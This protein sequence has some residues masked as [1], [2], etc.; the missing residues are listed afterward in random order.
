MNNGHEK[1]DL[2]AVYSAV[3]DYHN[4]LVHMRFTVAGLYLAASGFLIGALFNGCDW[5]GTKLSVSLL[6]LILTVIAWLLEIRTYQLLE[7]LGNKGIEIESKLKLGDV[8]GFFALMSHQPISPRLPFIKTRLSWCPKI[9]RYIISH[10]L[11]LDLLYLCITVFWILI[12]L[13]Y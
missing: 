5:C 4:N 10:S 11:G 8:Q 12:L 9:V 7:N 1:N 13:F 6:G 3:V 2:I